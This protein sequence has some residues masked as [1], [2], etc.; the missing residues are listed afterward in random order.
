M[1]SGGGRPSGGPRQPL[2]GAGDA[3]RPVSGPEAG[4][5]SDYFRRLHRAA[6]VPADA[7][8]DGEMLYLRT[9]AAGPVVARLAL[10]PARGRTPP[11]TNQPSSDQPSSDQPGSDQAS[12][13]ETASVVPR[14]AAGVEPIGEYQGSGLAQATYLVRNAGG[15]VVHL[16][17]LLYLVVS[18]IDGRRT[19]GEVAEQ[20]TAGFG[21][22]VSAGNIEFLLANKLPPL[23]LL[24]VADPS[25]ATGAPGK[26]PAVLT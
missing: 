3:D 9:W 14:L 15:Q 24:P 7:A 18:A 2:S 26:D 4:W 17:R 6:A 5:I 1:H 16:S 13:D 10:P 12:G 22:T 8:A 25:A 21:R 20:V 23:G 11:A 19:V